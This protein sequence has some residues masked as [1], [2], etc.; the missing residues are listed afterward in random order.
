MLRK[1]SST[2]HKAFYIMKCQT[3]KQRLEHDKK[4]IKARAQQHKKEIE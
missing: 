3:V 1:Q 4:Q 2:V